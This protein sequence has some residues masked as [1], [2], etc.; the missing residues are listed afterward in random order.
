[1]RALGAFVMTSVL[2]TA[3]MVISHGLSIPDPARRFL[4]TAQ[5]GASSE[6][7]DTL[8]FES[9]GDSTMTSS[10][11]PPVPEVTAVP[12]PDSE[13]GNS[14]RDDERAAGM[15]QGA[16]GDDGEDDAM[17]TAGD[18]DATGDDDVADA[19][20]DDEPAATGRTTI[21]TTPQGQQTPSSTPEPSSEPS[22]TATP[23]AQ[24]SRASETPTP[25]PTPTPTQASSLTR[26]PSDDDD[27]RHRHDW[28][29]D[30]DRYDDRDGRDD[31]GWRFLWWRFGGDDDRRHH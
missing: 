21:D 23:S 8:V 27:D 1:M 6:G 10:E 26:D 15:G 4:P 7:G 29:R 13:T 19:G 22:P 9:N 11:D 20:G 28:D 31:D 16:V 12:T 2:F 25:T 24:R 18:S 5:D 30:D 17:T 14:L 3:A